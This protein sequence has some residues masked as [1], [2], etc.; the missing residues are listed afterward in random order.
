MFWEKRTGPLTSTVSQRK[1]KQ[2]VVSTAAIA[3]RKVSNMLVPTDTE[4]TDRVGPWI[5]TI[6]GHRFYFKDSYPSDIVLKDIATAL[7]RI[8]RWGGHTVDDYSVV[9][10]AMLTR[11]LVEWFCK[12]TD[13]P[14]G[15]EIGMQALH[16]DSQEIY[17]GDVL[18][19]L[20]GLLVYYDAVE[21][22]AW[23]SVAGWL[24]I[25]IPLYSTTVMA[26]H[27]AQLIEAKYNTPFDDGWVMMKIDAWKC[28]MFHSMACLEAHEQEHDDFV[29]AQVSYGNKC[30]ADAFIM[31][32]ETLMAMKT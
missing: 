32:H 14:Y 5:K 10:H 12:L 25:P 8:P 15:Y 24:E 2:I 22:M 11:Q 21:I 3:P 26:D 20:K 13:I 18:T 16:H 27:M 19:P 29:H 17:V 28:D 6:S 4:D 30:M 31:E 23:K 7:S 9:A 1:L